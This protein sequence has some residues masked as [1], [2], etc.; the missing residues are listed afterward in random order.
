MHL[1]DLV[2]PRRAPRHDEVLTEGSYRLVGLRD[3]RG[4]DCE[5]DLALEDGKDATVAV[6]LKLVCD[7]KP[8]ANPRMVAR[9]GEPMT[10]AVGRNE[11]QADGSHVVTKG[12]RLSMRVDKAMP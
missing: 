11:K 6:Q 9:L 4:H 7:G 10:V 3:E 12:F 5:A 1:Q 2:S 8:A